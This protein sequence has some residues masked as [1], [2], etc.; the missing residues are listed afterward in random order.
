MASFRLAEV[1]HAEQIAAAAV[2]FREYVDWLGVDLSFQGFEAELASLPGKYAPPTGELLLAYSID[3]DALGCVAVRPLEGT[4][5][6]EMKRLYVRPVARGLRIGAALVAA[7]IRSARELGYAEMKLDTLPSMPQALALYKR[8]GFS[9]IP[10]YYHNPV[11]GTVYL[12]K[13]LSPAAAAA[14]RS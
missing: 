10:A 6:C 2:L 14:A 12:G 13:R 8:C 7:I 4:A 11:P 5:V 3:G 1:R 9:E